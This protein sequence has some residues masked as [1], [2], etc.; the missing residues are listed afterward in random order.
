MGLVRGIDDW[1]RLGQDDCYEVDLACGVLRKIGCSD[2]SRYYI[3]QIR[4]DVR[5]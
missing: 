3:R 1:S 4:L 5:L 2:F